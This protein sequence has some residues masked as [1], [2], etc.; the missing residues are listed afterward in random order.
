MHQNIS[1]LR[2]DAQYKFNPNP[3]VKIMCFQ[4]MID[5]GREKKT[6]EN[7]LQNNDVDAM[8]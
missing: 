1:M 2:A 6:L 8:N 7:S 4:K 5:T 3:N